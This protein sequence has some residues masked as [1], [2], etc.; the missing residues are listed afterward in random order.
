MAAAS[1][2]TGC[3]STLRTAASTERRDS[4]E[5]TRAAARILSL[6]D[7]FAPPHFQAVVAP[8]DRGAME[9]GATEL[10]HLERNADLFRA[11]LSA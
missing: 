5:S 10:A 11:R 8:P 9:W 3:S 6:I 2:F 4:W 7:G 1:G